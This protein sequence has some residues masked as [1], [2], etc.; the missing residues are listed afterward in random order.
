MMIVYYGHAARGVEAFLCFPAA[1][2]LMDQYEPYGAFIL[3]PAWSRK[4]CAWI[5]TCPSSTGSMLR[6]WKTIRKK[7][8]EAY[9]FPRAIQN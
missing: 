1:Q 4:D 6:S 3:P 2:A 5:E 8:T 9:D 7:I